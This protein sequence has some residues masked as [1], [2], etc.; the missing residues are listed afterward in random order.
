MSGVAAVGK[1]TTT[2][3]EAKVNT[4]VKTAASELFPVPAREYLREK[5]TRNLL[6]HF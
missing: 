4:T 2:D 3:I 1:T 6:K 5:T